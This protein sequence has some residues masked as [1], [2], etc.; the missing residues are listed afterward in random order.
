[1]VLMQPLVWPNALLLPTF[2]SPHQLLLVSI[3]CTVSK[4]LYHLN[5]FDF[6]FLSFQLIASLKAVETTLL[7]SVKTRGPASPALYQL[8]QAAASIKD[9]LA[10]LSV[11]LQQL[12]EQRRQ[13]C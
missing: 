10:E 11:L 13:R 6:T 7:G 3:D 4:L 9:Q 1:M 8:A 12:S 5:R 2:F